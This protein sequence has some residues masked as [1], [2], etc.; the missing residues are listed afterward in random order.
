MTLEDM[1]QTLRA[2]DLFAE[3]EMLETL[4]PKADA[5]LAVALA[6][7]RAAKF[8]QHHKPDFGDE[9]VCPHGIWEGYLCGDCLAAAILALAPADDLAEVQALRAERD[10]AEVW[11]QTQRRRAEAAE[12][13][14]ARL[15]EA[16]E[17][18]GEQARLA[19]L[20]HS[21]GDAGRQAL[22]ADG[23]KRARAALNRT[24][25]GG[26]ERMSLWRWVGFA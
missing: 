23:G 20:I 15:R 26:C 24:A 21:E 6:Y 8:V 9:G 18:Y 3:A 7:Q 22:D 10:D 14:V 25:Q 13:E 16:L 1:A 2:R 19:R 4:T 12:A 11:E 17:W 5:R